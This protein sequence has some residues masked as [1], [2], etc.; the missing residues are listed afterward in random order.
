ML[1]D[2]PYICKWIIIAPHH[3]APCEGKPRITA[4]SISPRAG[5]AESASMSRRVMTG[6]ISTQQVVGDDE[7]RNLSIFWK[8]GTNTD[9]WI[10]NNLRALREIQESSE[11]KFVQHICNRCSDA[12]WHHGCLLWVI[13][14]NRW[15][16]CLT[17]TEPQW[18]LFHKICFQVHF[19]G[20]RS[21]I[22]SN[23]TQL[24]SKDPKNKKASIGSDNGLMPDRWPTIIYIFDGLVPRRIYASI[25]HYW[26]FVGRNQILSLD[27]QLKETSGT[28]L[29]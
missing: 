12:A 29:S 1:G 13:V 11:K 9:W 19:L 24:V 16:L 21:F 6:T 26:H 4:G 7:H 15:W 25:V 8:T 10:Q 28:E 17:E 27:I 23:L 14:I 22:Y 18:V 20:K 2:V 5:N 3:W